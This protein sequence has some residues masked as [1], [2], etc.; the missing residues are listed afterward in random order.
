MIFALVLSQTEPVY[1]LKLAKR[2]TQP[3]NSGL[4]V[5]FQILQ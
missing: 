5:G 4:R 3:L 2:V 1:L